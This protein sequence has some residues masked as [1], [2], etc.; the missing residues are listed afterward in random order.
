M[1]VE[2]TDTTPP[3]ISIN[4]DNPITLIQGTAYTERPKHDL[5]HSFMRINNL[6]IRLNLTFVQWYW[7]YDSSSINFQSI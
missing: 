1:G 3:V 7:V 4:G 5:S 6:P 2:T